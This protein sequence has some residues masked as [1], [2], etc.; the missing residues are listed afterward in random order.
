MPVGAEQAALGGPTMWARQPVRVEVTFEPKEANA[1]IHEFADRKV[2]HAPIIPYPARWLHMSHFFAEESTLLTEIQP[3]VCSGGGI[4]DSG[5]QTAPTPQETRARRWTMNSE[6]FTF[7]GIK[8]KGV[9][10][11]SETLRK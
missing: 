11:L 4:D 1:G 5:A 6:F 8:W 10:P 9:S 3:V 7:H 2:Y